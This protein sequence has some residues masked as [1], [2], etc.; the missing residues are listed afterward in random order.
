MTKFRGGYF[1]LLFTTL[2]LKTGLSEWGTEKKEREKGTRQVI[3]ERVLVVLKPGLLN[4][5]SLLVLILRKSDKEVNS[6]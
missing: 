5:Y 2:L 1:L 3:P 4:N 6:P